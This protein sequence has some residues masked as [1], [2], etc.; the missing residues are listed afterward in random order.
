MY[1]GAITPDRIQSSVIAVPP[2][3][4][5]DDLSLNVEANRSIIQ[6]IGNGGVT[7]FLY[8]GNANFYNVSLSEY[9]NLLTMLSQVAGDDHWIIPSAGPSFGVMMD[10]AAILKQHAFPTAMVLPPAFAFTPTGV[11]TGFRKFVDAYGKPSVLYIK[12]KGVIE[13]DQV[14]KL[15]DEGLISWVKYAIVKDNPA[16]DDYLKTLTDAIDP[17]FIVSGIGEQPAIIHLRDF[18]LGGFTAGCVCVAPSLSAQML[19]AIADGQ[20]DKAEQLRQVFVPLED[21]R[22]NIS[23]IR[24]LHDAVELAGIA[25][26]GN[27]LPL[28]SNLNDEEKNQVRQAAV[29][30]LAADKTTKESDK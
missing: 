2:L 4:R 3:S 13:V 24:V 22:N 10:Q 16:E 6:H 9:D 5:H 30:L 20:F 18:G 23:P 19:R 11:E 1:T 14:R 29:A 7:T 26:T 21:L 17:K 12:N 25:Q 15:Y 28:L 8:G 27:A